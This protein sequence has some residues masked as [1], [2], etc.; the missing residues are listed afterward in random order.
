MLVQRARAAAQHGACFKVALCGAQGSGKTTL[1]VVLQRLLQARG[2]AT[3]VLSLDDFY[4]TRQQRAELAERVHPL[5]QTRGVPGTHDIALA[6]QVVESLQRAGEVALPA[7]DKARDERRAPQDW[8]SVAAPVQVVLFEGWCLCAAPQA[9]AA[10]ARPVNELEAHED[11]D[12]GWRR[13]VNTALAGDYRRLCN[14]FDY[15]VFLAAPGFDVVYQ[16]RLQQEQQ[17]RQQVAAQG[18][19]TSRMM[20]DAQLGRFVRHYER[21]TRHMLEDMPARADVVIRLD[22]ARAMTLEFP[23][24][25][26]APEQ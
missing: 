26:E 18:A 23:A 6:L 5:L 10:L 8:P 11:A 3:A 17:L 1:A 7:F 2:L 21:L 19:D 25:D 16:W 24:G 22:S 20:S 4:L 14:L 13:Y 9:A 15:R 12:G